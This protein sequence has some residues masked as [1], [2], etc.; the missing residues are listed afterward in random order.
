VGMDAGDAPDLG[1]DDTERTDEPEVDI[2]PCQEGLDPEFVAAL[3][4]ALETE[5]DAGTPAA[6]GI[7]IGVASPEF[8]LR[9]H[10]MG[11]EDAA[12]TQPMQADAIFD[13]GSIQK[14]LRWVLMWRLGELGMLPLDAPVND[15]VERPPLLDARLFQLTNHTSGLKHWDQ[16]QQMLADAFAEPTEPFS[17]LDMMDYLEADGA[18]LALPGAEFHYSNYGPLVAGK[19]MENALGQSVEDLTREHILVQLDMKNTSFQATE[20]K[21]ARL[22]DGYWAD[23]SP[24]TWT[25]DYRQTMALSSAAG[26]LLY[27]NACDMLLYG[28]AIA[29]DEMFLSAQTKATMIS[30]EFEVPW[31][32]EDGFEFGYHYFGFQRIGFLEGPLL[33]GHLGDG[34]HGHSTSFMF[35]PSD[36]TSFIVLTNVAAVTT[37][38]GPGDGYLTHIVA[39][40]VLNNYD[41]TP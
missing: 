6:T 37:G 30:E 29:N 21:P 17:Y 19:A 24:H 8:G 39:L 33:Y 38:D 26:G 31:V 41:F 10:T 1:A 32:T 35:R 40:S 2:A 9:I 16:T 25:D 20:S 15:Y 23:G 11:F 28:Q 27:S 34:Q 18:T 36:G 4:A 13:I 12:G 5:Y 7:V 14:N 22:V 3:E